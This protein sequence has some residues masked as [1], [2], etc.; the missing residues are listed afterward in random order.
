MYARFDDMAPA[1]AS[2]RKEHALKLHIVQHKSRAAS[3]ALA[4]R[5]VPGV[6]QYPSGGGGGEQ[7]PAD[8]VGGVKQCP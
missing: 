8:A 2:M 4:P 6:A 1:R 5:W 7:H 3:R